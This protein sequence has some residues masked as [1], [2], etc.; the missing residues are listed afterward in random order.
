MLNAAG[1]VSQA[2][3]AAAKPVHSSCLIASPHAVPRVSTALMPYSEDYAN[4]ITVLP[5]TSPSS[6]TVSFWSRFFR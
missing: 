1:L 3:C 4:L 5:T 2:C 6:V